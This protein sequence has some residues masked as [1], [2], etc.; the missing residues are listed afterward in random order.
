V[1]EAPE[2]RE[3]AVL[4]EEIEHSADLIYMNDPEA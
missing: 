1:A 2:R 4:L 3:P